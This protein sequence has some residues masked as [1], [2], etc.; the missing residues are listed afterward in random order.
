ML[1]LGHLRLTF[2]HIF[3]LHTT[4]IIFPSLFIYFPVLDKYIIIHFD[5]YFYSILFLNYAKT[6]YYKKVLL[7]ITKIFNIYLHVLI[8]FQ[9]IL[10]IIFF[11][12]LDFTDIIVTVG[13]YLI[14]EH[15]TNGCIS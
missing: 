7:L 8:N 10:H 15:V 1:N 11:D 2:S 12:F 5:I 14:L 6:A 9:D 13:K 3:N 4:V